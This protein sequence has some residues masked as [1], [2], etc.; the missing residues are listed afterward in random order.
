MVVSE[1]VRGRHL[2]RGAEPGASPIPLP[3]S[4]IR[5]QTGSS[6]ARTSLRDAEGRSGAELLQT[7]QPHCSGV[8][9]AVGRPPILQAGSPVQSSTAP[10]PESQARLHG[11]ATPRVSLLGRQ[12]AG[13]APKHLAPGARMT[14]RP[15]FLP[16]AAGERAL[17]A[18]MDL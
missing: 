14:R 16:Q 9:G 1:L 4:G 7:V 3:R 18:K 10:L 13:E 12:G 6:S 15:G 17:R 5:L 11:V 8:N 2:F